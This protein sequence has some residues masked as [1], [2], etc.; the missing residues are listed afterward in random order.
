VRGRSALDALLWN[1]EYYEQAVDLALYPEHNWASGCRAD[2][3]LGQ[4]WAYLLGLGELLPVDHVR[5]A[6]QSIVRHNY[7]HGLAGHSQQPRAF[8][9]DDDQGLLNCTWPRGG[10]PAVPTPYSDEVW[11]GIEYEVAALLLY[12]GEHDSAVRLVEAVRARYNGRKQSPWNDIECG[13]HHVRAMSAWALLEAAAGFDYDAGAAAL[14]FAPARTPENFHAP[15]VTRAGWGGFRQTVSAG[16]QSARLQLAYGSFILRRLRLR[17]AGTLL[18]AH[19]SVE[20][21]NWPAVFSS[22]GADVSAD[23]GDG[24][25]LTAGQTPV[26]TLTLEPAALGQTHAHTP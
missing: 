25:R 5:A 3:L 26:M 4:W 20:G 23:L 13:D 2:Q 18:S 1:G 21:E 12:A 15:F 11:T 19:L 22:D 9:T 14:G 16:Q 7:R 10:R 24:L 6:A 17:A 8:V